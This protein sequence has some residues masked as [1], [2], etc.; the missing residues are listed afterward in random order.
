M[1]DLTASK[2]SV[3]ITK[4][5]FKELLDKLNYQY[6]KINNFVAKN[7]TVLLNYTVH[8]FLNSL[9]NTSS[10]MKIINTFGFNT[11]MEI[12][13]KL[14]KLINEKAS[15]VDNIIPIEKPLSTILNEF[16]NITNSTLENYYEYYTKL[17]DIVSKQ[18]DKAQET[19][20]EIEQR[21]KDPIFKILDS[22]SFL[23]DPLWDKMNEFLG[24][25]NYDFTLSLYYH[26]TEGK[27][28]TFID[29]L[30]LDMVIT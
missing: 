26:V 7:Y 30:S 15:L 11:L 23:K 19:I 9:N 5:N 28:N 22:L 20:N 13:S 8:E 2:F 12:L 1:L 6:N 14:E 16:H 24:E 4:D 29:L 18:F 17:L 10:F 25:D 27:T 21:I 3:I